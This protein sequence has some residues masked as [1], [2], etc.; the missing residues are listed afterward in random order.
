MKFL[1]A[2]DV[3]EMREIIKMDIEA[4]YD[5]EIF[6]AVD[7]ANAIELINSQGPFDLV[8]CDYNM[9]HK[10]GAEVFTELRKN[11]RTTPFLLISTH[12]D[13]FE[14]FFLKDTNVS[15]LGK[16][17]NDEEFTVLIEQLLAQKS[18]RTQRDSYL[19]VSI[20]VLSKVVYPGVSLYIR[21]NEG[22]YVKVL[23]LDAPFNKSE[24]DRF[25]AK[26][27]THLFVE[28]IDIKILISNF[29]KDVFAKF[30]WDNID[31][32]K[33][34][35]NLEEDWSLVLDCTRNFGWPESIKSMT[36]ENIARTVEI[37]KKNPDLVQLW[38]KLKLSKNKGQV[39]PHCYFLVLLMTSILKELGWDSESTLK[40]I[41]FAA[42][43]HDMELTDDAFAIKLQR[44]SELGFGTAT[45]SK[46]DEVIFNHP[47]TAARFVSFWSSCPPD[48]DKLILQHHERFD[49]KGFPNKL[50][51]LNIFSLA[52]VMIIAE[53]I[54]YQSLLNDELNLLEYFKS[55]EEYYSRGEYKKVFEATCKVLQNNYKA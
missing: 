36:R 18:L 17:Y 30:D 39:A 31:V 42:L 26:G 41:T 22:Q 51:F 2:D 5:V 28:L 50:T 43:L 40:K 49:G 52:G 9:P 23:K 3:S 25:S 20:S 35:E 27:L 12:A 8:I 21:L 55:K 15:T 37:L 6:E 44:L 47:I 4:N 34:V 13:K 24:F 53:D 45:K 19:P 7:G 11:N 48:V 10:N 16:P 29:R 14:E 54:I 32:K 38:E 46:G 33:A 1:I